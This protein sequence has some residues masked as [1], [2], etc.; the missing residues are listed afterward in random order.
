M[1]VF[2]SS[3]PRKETS[4]TL[5][6]Q[7]TR[8]RIC[9]S[10]LAVIFYAIREET[11]DSTINRDNWIENT[12]SPSMRKIAGKYASP[13][14]R[15]RKLLS[16]SVLKPFSHSE[17]RPR[18]SMIARIFNAASNDHKRLT[19][20]CTAMNIDSWN[21]SRQST[22][23]PT[24][25]SAVC[26]RATILT[27]NPSSKLYML[28]PARTRYAGFRFYFMD[29]FSKHWVDRYN[30]RSL[31]QPAATSPPPHSTLL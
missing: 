31:R 29:R 6:S 22:P 2:S 5:S 1:A 10:R 7:R 20:V 3:S 14:L 28:C 16:L 18:S 13:L 27:A 23:I 8:C 30:K 11:R 12:P 9:N 25:W 19:L 4:T 26:L 21:T 17:V 24:S 15:E